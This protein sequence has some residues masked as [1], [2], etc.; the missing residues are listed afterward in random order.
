MEDATVV[1]AASAVIC[2]SEGRVLLIKRGNEPG[3][4]LWSV[5]G[6][7]VDPGE[8]LA[9]AAAREAKEETGLEVN[10]ERELWSL[11]VPTGDGR[12]YEIHDFAASVIGGTLAAGDDADEVRWVTPDE[13]DELALTD[14]LDE[15]LRNAGLIPAK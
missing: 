9:E 8:S 13:L 4:G 7:C 6:G 11:R 10:V 12:M 1:L 15:Y 14:N 2:D 5:P 3:K